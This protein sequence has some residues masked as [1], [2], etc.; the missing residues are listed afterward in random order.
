M[1]TDHDL[2]KVADDDDDLKNRWKETVSDG[3]DD[4]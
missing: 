3:Y 1:T 2:L 4:A